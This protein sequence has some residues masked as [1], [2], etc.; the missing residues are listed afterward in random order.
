MTMDGLDTIAGLLVMK[1]IVGIPNYGFPDF[2]LVVSGRTIFS[3]IHIIARS[4]L[5]YLIHT[6]A[7]LSEKSLQT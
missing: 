2:I 5:S 7:Q 6:V 4:A 3:T 1:L